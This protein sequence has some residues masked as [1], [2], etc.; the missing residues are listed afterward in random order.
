MPLDQRKLVL[1]D[2][3]AQKW[4]ELAVSCAD[5]PSA[6][7]DGR[8]FAY[9]S[10]PMWS[11]DG[12]YIYF[13]AWL[14]EFRPIYRIRVT[15]QHTERLLDSSNLG[16]GARLDLVGLGPKDEP[17]VSVLTTNADVYAVGWAGPR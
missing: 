12:K 15:D 16:V 17:V 7:K 4:S 1:F 13:E 6:A 10:N 5:N 3:A 8:C 2:M 11:K 9:I 14:D